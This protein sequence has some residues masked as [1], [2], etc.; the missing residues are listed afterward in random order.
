MQ[1][2]LEQ[3]VKNNLEII[4]DGRCQLCGA[5]TL[6]GVA[7]CVETAG[8][9]THKISHAKAVESMS[10]FLCVDAHALTHTQI[11]GRWNN[12]FHLARLHLILVDRIQWEYAYSPLLSEVLDVYKMNRTQ[13][14]I[15]SPD[16]AYR[17]KI[18]V[19]DVD[20]AQDEKTHIALAW[21]WAHEVYAS[22]TNGHHIVAT[23]SQQFKDTA[24]PKLQAS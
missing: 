10:L 1:Q 3:A 13:E 24:H 19:L 4:Q 6:H 20:A 15:H 22:Y 5:N 18:T 16:A 23:L 12:H 17:T 7:E 11:H 9:I 8:Y 21:R 14:Y 2:W